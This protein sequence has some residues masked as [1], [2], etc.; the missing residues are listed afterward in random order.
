MVWLMSAKKSMP[1]EYASRRKHRS[2][3]TSCAPAE[4]AMRNPSPSWPL[5]PLLWEYVRSHPRSAM[6]SSFCA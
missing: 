4:V 1:K 5:T 6:V 3:E 2:R